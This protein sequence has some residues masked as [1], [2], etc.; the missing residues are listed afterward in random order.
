MN[1]LKWT[2]YIVSSN[3]SKHFKKKDNSCFFVYKNF[4]IEKHSMKK[5]EKKDNWE[6][7][8]FEEED[9]K[10]WCSNICYNFN[11]YFE[12]DFIN[13]DLFGNKV[14][15]YKVGD[16]KIT[17]EEVKSTY[18]FTLKYAQLVAEI[19]DQKISCLK[20]F[21]EVSSDVYINGEVMKGEF[22]YLDLIEE[23]VESKISRIE[24]IFSTK[25]HATILIEPT[26]DGYSIVSEVEID[27]C[28][29]RQ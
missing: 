11:D 19:I 20:C 12:L 7:W 24:V 23:I 2:L 14:K 26:L 29:K 5:C 6:N 18:I 22:T 21:H 15:S 16:I 25:E 4:C 17:C 9:L 28:M 3:L 8:D 27:I 13:T 1:I 10:M